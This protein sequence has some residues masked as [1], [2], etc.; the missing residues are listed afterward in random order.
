MVNILLVEDEKMNLNLLKYYVDEYF[1]TND[2]NIEIDLA[3]DGSIASNLL[4][5]KSYDLIILDVIMPNIDGFKVLNKIRKLYNSNKPYICMATAM[6]EQK[7]KILFR[8]KGANS[9]I[10]KPY[11]KKMITAIFDRFKEIKFAVTEDNEDNIEFDDFIDFF[12]EDDEFNEFEE[13][14]TIA[15][16]TSPKISAKEFLKDCGDIDYI[17]DSIDEIDE[18]IEVLIE[19]LD[20]NTFKSN[21]ETIS[22]ILSKYGIFLNSFS[23]FYEISSAIYLLNK[24]INKT[25][26]SKFDKSKS[27]YIVEFI[28]AIFNDLIHWKKSVFEEQNAIDVFYINAS[29]LSSCIQ[30]QELMKK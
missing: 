24:T 7:H 2:I 18:D 9:Y 17:M 10:I 12:D 25:D 4:K 5:N 3:Q 26:L 23:D 28:K 11:N 15:N 30:L 22:F 21:H 6:G 20:I 29:I 16:N 8:I 19:L 27:I 13:T 14:M 1:N